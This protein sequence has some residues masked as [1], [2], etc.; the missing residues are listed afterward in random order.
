MGIFKSEKYNHLKTYAIA[1]FSLMAIFYLIDMIQMNT[2]KSIRNLADSDSRSTGPNEICMEIDGNTKFDLFGLKNV[3]PD[4]GEN[5]ELKFCQNVEKHSSSCIYKRNDTSIVKLAET[6]NGKEKNKNKV[7]V[8]NS[9][10]ESKRKVTM[11]LA[12]GDPYVNDEKKRYEY[13]FI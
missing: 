5:I 10:T 12:P 7:K 9:K 8:S 1:T 3:N 4:L 13:I 6:I 2:K 11:H